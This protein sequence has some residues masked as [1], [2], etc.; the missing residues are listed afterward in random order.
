V[1]HGSNVDH[2]IHISDLFSNKR[3]GTMVLTF[4]RDDNL[5]NGVFFV[6]LSSVNGLNRIDNAFKVFPTTSHELAT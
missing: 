3:N 2:M 5:A 1:I 6:N 4:G